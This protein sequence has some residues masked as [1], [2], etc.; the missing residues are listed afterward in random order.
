MHPRT[1]FVSQGKKLAFGAWVVM[2]VLFCAPALPQEHQTRSLGGSKQKTNLE[3]LDKQLHDMAAEY[4][5]QYGSVPRV[6]LFDVAF[7]STPA[8]DSVL[9]RN[10]LLLVTVVTQDAAELPLKRI[11]VRGIDGDEI[12]LKV[13][14]SYYANTESDPLVQKTLGRFRA[15][16]FCLLPIANTFTKGALQIDFAKNRVGFLLT[17]LPLTPPDVHLLADKKRFPDPTKSIST[18]ALKTILLREF[19]DFSR[20]KFTSQP[21]S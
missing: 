21:P 11:Y 12:D 4:G 10:A 7:P 13:V 14:S 19:P 2:A 1:G 8:E 9:N 17:E 3:D 20:S 5:P 6:A 18:D 16:T 15:Q